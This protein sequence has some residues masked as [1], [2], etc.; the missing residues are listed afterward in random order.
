MVIS[1]FLDLGITPAKS[2]RVRFLVFGGTSYVESPRSFKQHAGE[3]R[4]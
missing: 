1:S 4:D 2:A 3:V